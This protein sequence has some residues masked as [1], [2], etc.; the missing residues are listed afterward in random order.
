MNTMDKSPRWLLSKETYD[1]CT[2]EILD[3]VQN[4]GSYYSAGI[5]LDAVRDKNLCEQLVQVGELLKQKLTLDNN[6]K[7]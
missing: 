2:P 4:I 1:A 7:I 6:K 3:Y 5:L